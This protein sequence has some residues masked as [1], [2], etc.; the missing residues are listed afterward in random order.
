MSQL[1]TRLHAL[2]LLDRAFNAMTDD[3]LAGTAA[4]LPEEHLTAI[5]ELCGAR[6]GGFTDPA[7]RTLAMRATA[8]R[9]RMNGGLEQLCTMLTD[10]C[11]AKCIELLGENSDNPTHDQLQD[12]V[13]A[14]IEEF[15][16]ADT[17]LM[18]ACSVAGEAAASEML[19]HVLKH[20]DT[21]ALPPAVKVEVAVLPA[22]S[23][24]EETKA[25]RK[26]AKERKQAEAAARRA[27]Q[28]KAK[29]R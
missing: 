8:A 12:V 21:L 28:A 6:E 4:A 27:Q 23:A 17:R 14:L 16:L 2:T 24:D 25:K 9:G 26:A 5:D 20:D 19:I 10:P 22:R 11:L 3:E 15:G 18:L 13:P 1:K 7:A 29:H